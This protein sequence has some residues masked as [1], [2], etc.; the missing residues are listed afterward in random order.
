ME[1]KRPYGDGVVSGYGTVDGR[2]V[3]V[4]SQDFT[5]FGGSLGQVN[6]EKIVKV[7]DFALQTGCPM[8]GILDGGGARIQEGVVSLACT[9]RSS[10]ATST[11]PASSR[12]SRSSWAPAAGGAVYSPAL[13]DFVVM[14]DKT[15]H[16]FITGPDVIKTVTGEDVDMEKLGGA[17]QHNANTRHLALP[18]RRR[19]GRDRVRPALLGFLPHNNLAE[20]PGLRRAVRS[21]RSPT[22]TAPSTRSSRTR[23]TSRTTCARSSS[24]IVDDGALP[25]D[26]VPVR[27]ERR[28]SA[29]AGSRATRSA[30]WPTSPCS[31]PAPWTSTPR[32]RPPASSG[33]AT[34]STS[35]IITLVDVPGLPAGQG[36]GVPRHHP[37]RRET[38]VRLRRGHRAAS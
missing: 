24:T 15:C 31:S 34:P 16:M 14:V 38:A 5:V 19:G 4:Y 9:A 21:W 22:T 28:S 3:C 32:R 2:P 1:K 30:S 7:Q 18:G 6:G 10:A 37:P 13:T 25:G 8:I 11:P 33:T 26:A 23:P 12:R 17:R 27:P 35:P 29:S 20:P 36:P